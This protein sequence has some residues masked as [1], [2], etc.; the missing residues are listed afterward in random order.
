VNIS[1]EGGGPMAAIMSKMGGN[2]ITSE[3]TSVSTDAVADSL[4]EVPAGY[5]VNKRS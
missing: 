2:S 1:F 4:F 5:K 3:V